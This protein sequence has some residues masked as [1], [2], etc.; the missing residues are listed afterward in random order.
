MKDNMSASTIIFVAL[1]ALIIASLPIWKHSKMWG[2][3]YTPSI[4]LG[5][6]L[7]AHIYTILFAKS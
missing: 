5:F 6:V 2:Q 3:G 7:A 4:F 1:I